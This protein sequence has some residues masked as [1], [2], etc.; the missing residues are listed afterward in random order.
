MLLTPVSYGQPVAPDAERH[1]QFLERG[2]AGALADAVDRALDLA[3]AALD[4]GDAV[5]DGEAEIVVAVRAEDDAVGVRDAL[6]D[7]GE[8]GAGF[9]RRGVADRVRQVDRRG[10]FADDRLDDAA[11]EIGIAPRRVLRRKLHIVGELPGEANRRRRPSRGT[12]R[13]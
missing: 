8:E 13:A 1:D 3:R 4:R 6:P 5:R 12:S 9:V 10:A 11:Q 2:V 7:V